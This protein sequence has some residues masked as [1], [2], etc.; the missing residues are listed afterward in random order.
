M[1][2]TAP[3]LVGVLAVLALGL[4]VLLAL[5]WRRR[6]H[7]LLAAGGWLVGVLLCQVLAVGLVAVVANNTYGFYNSWSELMGGRTE[8]VGGPVANQMVPA[9]GSQGSVVSLSV[10]A[11]AIPGAHGGRR[12]NV[13]VWLPK[14]YREPQFSRASFPVVLI[15]PGQPGTPQGVFRQFAVGSQ[16]VAAIAQ[17]Q[18]RPFIAVMAPLM[19]DPPRDTE[20]TDIPGGPHAE[21]WLS[22]VVPAAVRAHFRVGGNR[23]RWS[24]MGWSTGGFCAAKL[25]L[26]QPSQFAAAVGIG[27]YYDAETDRS[28]GTLFRSRKEQAENSPYWLI[29]RT[30]LS[31]VNLLIITSRADRSST[32]VCTTPTRSR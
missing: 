16:S 22:R 8:P 19:I 6:P 32:T 24:V 26:R 14:E 11:P 12:M 30:Q 31:P 20:C 4:P 23:Q 13:L 15:L 7:G 29:G 18:V 21:S 10:T 5:T 2:L 17:H 28:T 25:L 9:D 3:A 27:G 1:A